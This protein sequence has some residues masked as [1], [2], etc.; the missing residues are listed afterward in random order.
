MGQILLTDFFPLRVVNTKA[1]SFT[2]QELKE[3][4]KMFKEGVDDS[5]NPQREKV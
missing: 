4:L 2:A 5:T 3:A 1:P